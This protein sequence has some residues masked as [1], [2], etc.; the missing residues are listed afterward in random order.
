MRYCGLRAPVELALAEEARLL[1]L[2]RDVLAERVADAERLV[3]WL[4]DQRRQCTCWRDMRKGK[5]G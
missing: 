1:R 2:Q 3:R 4:E 5:V